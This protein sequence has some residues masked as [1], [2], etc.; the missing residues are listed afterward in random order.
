MSDSKSMN[1]VLLPGMTGPIS[2]HPYVEDLQGRLQLL[3]AQLQAAAAQGLTRISI[4]PNPHKNFGEVA[5]AIDDAIRSIFPHASRVR[6]DGELIGY[7]MRTQ[8][9][10]MEKFWQLSEKTA[11]LGT[12]LSIVPIS[13]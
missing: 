1:E 8:R 12:S 2:A 5:H 6:C 7:E 4:N 9:D 3:E 13:R 11:G 10:G